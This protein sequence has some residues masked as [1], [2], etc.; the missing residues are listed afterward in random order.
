MD[1]YSETI[2]E[3]FKNPPNKGPLKGATTSAEEDNPLCGDK[4][5]VHVIIKDNRI[6]DATFEG[7]G[8]AI[9]QAS[10]SMLTESIIGKSIN[11]VKKM[12]NEAIYDMLGIEISPGR[13]KCALLGLTT[14]KKCLL[15]YQYPKANERAHTGKN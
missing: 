5:K 3:Y 6:I 8:C 14:L 11:T 1:L 9:S 15:N 13:V 2:L 12:P 4:I 10:V 7:E